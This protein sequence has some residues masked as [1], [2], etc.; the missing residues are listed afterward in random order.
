MRWGER[1]F[2][3]THPPST[4]NPLVHAIILLHTHILSMG[5]LGC[6]NLYRKKRIK[7]LCTVD[8]WVIILTPL[9]CVQRMNFKHQLK[10]ISSAI[11]LP[12]LAQQSF[13][14]YTVSG[15]RRGTSQSYTTA[16]STP[17]PG[18]CWLSIHPCTV[19]MQLGSG[20]PPD[21]FYPKT[22]CGRRCSRGAG[23]VSARC[24]LETLRTQVVDYLA[25]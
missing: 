1:R 24:L 19:I 18:I 9:T 2:C 8:V 10:R 17:I 12:A 20:R 4:S 13:Y 11:A 21:V 5:V 3:H 14:T 16:G 23:D 25:V 7:C 22:I 15:L 6:T